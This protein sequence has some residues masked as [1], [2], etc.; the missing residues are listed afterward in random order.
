MPYVIVYAAIPPHTHSH[1]KKVD[2]R[3][4]RLS[5]LNIF[6]LGDSVSSESR[7]RKNNNKKTLFFLA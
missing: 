3:S 7:A 5:K 4:C 1:T 2:E 6:S